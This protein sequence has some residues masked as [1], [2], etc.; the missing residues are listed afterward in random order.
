MTKKELKAFLATHTVHISLRAV[1]PKFSTF[2]FVK[3]IGSEATECC[4]L[5]CNPGCMFKPKYPVHAQYHLEADRFYSSD[6]DE[7]DLFS[8]IRAAFIDRLIKDGF[9]P[10]NY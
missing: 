1:I 2:F 6:K 10:D 9:L 5:L 7:F 3:D 4:L 8:A